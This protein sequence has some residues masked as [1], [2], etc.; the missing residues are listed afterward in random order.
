MPAVTF[1]HQNLGHQLCKK[2][3]LSVNEN[4][5][6]YHHF[7]D[8]VKGARIEMEGSGGTTTCPGTAFFGGNTV[9]SCK[10]N[11]LPLIQQ[12]LAQQTY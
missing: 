3:G 6:I 12:Q 8:L 11:L 5:T 4:Y 10:K 7:Y 9:E 2:Y 1:L